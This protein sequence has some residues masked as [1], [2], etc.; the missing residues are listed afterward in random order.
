[1]ELANH[2]VIFLPWWR[3]MSW[4]L[5]SAVRGWFGHAAQ[6]RGQ[7]SWLT[8]LGG[9]SGPQGIA[10]SIYRLGESL[11]PG[12][13]VF[14]FAGR[15]NRRWQCVYVGETADLRSRVPGHEALPEALLLGATHVHVLKDG[16]P[17]SRRATADRLIFMYGPMLNAAAAPLLN[18]LVAAGAPLP[19][20]EPHQLPRLAV[21]TG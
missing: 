21:A 4:S 11:P 9:F 3:A 15:A 18:E 12:P 2:F 6:P 14:L 17:A 13:G 20:L 19:P 7:A 16:D 5:I 10:M 8:S 1:L